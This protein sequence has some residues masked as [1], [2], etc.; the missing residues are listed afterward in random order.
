MDQT[1][2]VSRSAGSSYTLN[3]QGPLAEDTAYATLRGIH[4]RQSVSKSLK[5]NFYY[6]S[7]NLKGKLV[8]ELIIVIKLTH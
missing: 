2:G 8:S 5:E 3:K 6:W 4:Q 1:R 7:I